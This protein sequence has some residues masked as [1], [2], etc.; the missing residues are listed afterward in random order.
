MSTSIQKR[1]IWPFELT[2]KLGEGGMG[3]VYRGRYV[4]NDKQ[5]AV[6]LLPPDVADEVV[7]AR[8][9]RELEILKKLRHPNIVYCFGGVAEG[10]Q[11]FYA[12]ELVE[13]G[14]LDQEIRRRGSLPWE[15]VVEYTL[16]MCSA[17]T[18]AHDRG[19]IH[20]DIKPGN[21]LI[22]DNGIL[23][24]SD[25][26]LACII[27]GTKLTMAGRTTGTVRYMAPEQIRGKPPASLHTDLYA[28]GC[29]M[30]EMLT[31]QTPFDGSTQAEILNK[32]L[33]EL[34]DP[35]S[36]LAR[37]C[38]AWLDALV[39]QLLEKQP[40]HRPQSAEKVAEKLRETTLT[41][42][43]GSGVSLISERK[44]TRV[45]DDIVPVRRSPAP[46]VNWQV[47]CLLLLVVLLLLW[48]FSLRGGNESSGRS[49]EL[50]LKAYHS[51]ETAVRIEAAGALARIDPSVDGTVE[52]LIAGLGDED[53]QIRVATIEALEEMGAGGRPA[54]SALK[55]LQQNDSEPMVRSQAEEAGKAI[56]ATEPESSSWFNIV[57]GFFAVIV[58][59]GWLVVKKILAE[60]G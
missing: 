6:K 42:R 29:V 18:Y 45:I 31:G 54:L 59:G 4:K 15:L 38:P 40:E 2:D 28:L 25:F 32:Q 51:H 48:N 26:G 19:V 49:G 52:A 47:P 37:D 9:E 13:G 30:Y 50:W 20:R 55:R 12:M 8:F 35:V 10:E 23:K 27:A 3:V 43:A 16:Q 22:G 53:S 56:A 24:L 58:T 21:F 1:W 14:T 5:V 33:K 17:L 44:K 7:L 36:T 39:L 57:V 34:P 41:I 46:K 11:R 60:D